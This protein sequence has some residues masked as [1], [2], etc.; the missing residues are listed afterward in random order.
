MGYLISLLF[1]K[2]NHVIYI[3]CSRDK[4][5][6]R[7]CSIGKLINLY[8]SETALVADGGPHPSGMLR[9]ADYKGDK[10]LK[11]CYSEFVH[12][13]SAAF[14]YYTSLRDYP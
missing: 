12:I 5:L 1:G 2:D 3:C 8:N 9:T 6:S 14:F 13:Y 11:S 4:E 7:T 10:A